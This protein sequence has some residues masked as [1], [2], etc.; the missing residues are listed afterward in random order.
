VDEF[1][2]SWHENA[3]ASTD[4][5]TVTPKGE[6]REW[7]AQSGPWIIFLPVIPILIAGVFHP[8]WWLILS[9]GLL[10]WLVHF[11]RG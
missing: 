10:A 11:L 1:P 3:E 4:A 9:V 7:L 8:I 2:M 5:M 6:P